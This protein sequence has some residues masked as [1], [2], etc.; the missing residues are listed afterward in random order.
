MK[1]QFTD[2]KAEVELPNG[3]LLALS[4]VGAVVSISKDGKRTTLDNPDAIK[5]FW[6]DVSNTWPASPVIPFDPVLNAQVKAA[7]EAVEA[8]KPRNLKATRDA[9]GSIRLTLDDGSVAVVP[10]AA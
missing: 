3:V 7:Q 10:P 1:H 8:N 6:F 4:T 5:T 2:L 9:D